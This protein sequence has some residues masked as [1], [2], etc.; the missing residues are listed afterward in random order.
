MQGPQQGAWHLR[1]GSG[2]WN[3]ANAW[4]GLP[5]GSQVTLATPPCLL[6]LVNVG[7]EAKSLGFLRDGR[8]RKGRQE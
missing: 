8:W 3:Q 5:L 6:S 1:L 2:P 7:C 4:R